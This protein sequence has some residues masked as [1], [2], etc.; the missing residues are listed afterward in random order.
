MS[1]AEERNRSHTSWAGVGHGSL[2]HDQRGCTASLR[3]EA[4]SHHAML[5]LGVCVVVAV[6]AVFFRRAVVC[7]ERKR[8][9]RIDAGLF[10]FVF[11]IFFP[12]GCSRWCKGWTTGSLPRPVSSQSSGLFFLYKRIGVLF[13]LLSVVFFFLFGDC[14]VECDFIWPSAYISY[15]SYK[16]VSPQTGKPC[17][18]ARGRP[19]QSSFD[20]FLTTGTWC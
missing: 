4:W 13:C 11:F 19:G 9:E 20:L 8:R 15:V 2:S 7:K 12:G 18:C 3:L 6:R 5:S 17:L 1:R 10:F 14:W 16:Q